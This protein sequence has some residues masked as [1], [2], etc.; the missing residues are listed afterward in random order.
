MKQGISCYSN[1]FLYTIRI[2]YIVFHFFPYSRFSRGSEICSR[3]GSHLLI[4]HVMQNR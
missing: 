1:S 3:H 4:V 2:L